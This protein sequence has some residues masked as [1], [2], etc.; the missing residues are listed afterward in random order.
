ME[1]GGGGGGGGGGGRERR[2]REVEREEGTDNGWFIVPLSNAVILLVSFHS[3]AVI[4]EQL[5]VIYSLPR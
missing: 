3:P 5:A 4:F 2:G 1:R